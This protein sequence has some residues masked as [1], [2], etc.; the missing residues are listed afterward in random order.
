MRPHALASPSQSA[1]PPPHPILAQQP[2]VRVAQRVLPASDAA[3]RRQ[4][5]LQAVPQLA[6]AHDAIHLAV[7]HIRC[8]TG[9]ALHASEYRTWNSAREAEPAAARTPSFS[10]Y[11]ASAGGAL[12]EAKNLPG[13][14]V[15]LMTS[16]SS[17]LPNTC[18]SP[19]STYAAL[20]VVSCR[21]IWNTNRS[22]VNTQC[23]VLPPLMPSKGA[24]LVLDL[25]TH[26]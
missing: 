21:R 17:R 26:D 11:A 13:T 14:L 23:S 15:N 22:S 3:L 19:C 16:R 6:A 10:K 20:L 1:E 24:S 2:A 5:P 9:G 18:I 4:R 7:Q 25:Q 12:Q 8:L